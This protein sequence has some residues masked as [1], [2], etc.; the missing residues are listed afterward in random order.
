MPRAVVRSGGG[1]CRRCSGRLWPVAEFL[2]RSDRQ[3]KIDL[4]PKPPAPDPFSLKR[5][6]KRFSS[7]G[8]ANRPWRLA[9]AKPLGTADGLMHQP[10]RA[11]ELVEECPRRTTSQLLGRIARAKAE[12]RPCQHCNASAAFAHP[13]MLPIAA[14]YSRCISPSL[15]CAACRRGRFQGRRPDLSDAVVLTARETGEQHRR[16]ANAAPD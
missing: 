11:S 1:G 10:P 14:S 3:T 2:E 8:A 15:P 9:W 7:L 4:C 6:R 12:G 5:R 13:T 16:A